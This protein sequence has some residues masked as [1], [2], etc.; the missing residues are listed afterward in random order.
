[1]NYDFM[2][3]VRTIGAAAR[4]VRRLTR[5]I[6]AAGRN[7]DHRA[8]AYLEARRDRA[9]RAYHAIRNQLAKEEEQ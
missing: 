8:A 2:G 6:S 9:L 7:R 5:A 1:M 4:E 3:R